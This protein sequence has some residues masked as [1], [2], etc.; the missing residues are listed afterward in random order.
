MNV[1]V[2]ILTENNREEM[3]KRAVESC[4]AQTRPVSQIIV[5]NDGLTELKLPKYPKVVTGKTPGQ[6]GLA[7]ARQQAFELLKSDC[8][9]VC[10]LDD[11]DELL[12]NHSEKLVPLLYKSAYGVSRAKFQYSDGMST[13]DPEPNNTGP[14]RYYDPEALLSQNIAP[15]SSYIHS[16]A[17]GFEV[18]WDPTIIRIEDWDFWGR[19]CIRY[20]PPAY[21]GAITNI[22]H[23][24]G[25]NLSG[26]NPLS[27]SMSCSWRDIVADRLR[28]LAAERRWHPT[29]E[30][31]ARFHIP[32][33]GVVMP[34][35]NAEK[36]LA[37]AVMSILRQTYGD[38]EIIAVNDGSTD[39][40]RAI[41]E[42]FAESDRRVRI[43]D[44]PGN[45]GVTKALNYGLLVS[46]S[47]YVARMDA[48][49]VSLPER[50]A[51]QMDFLDSNKDVSL[52]GTCFVSMDKDLSYEI[53]RNNIGGSPDEILTKLRTSNC[54]GHPTVMVRRRALEQMGG[55]NEAEAFRGAEDYELWARMAAKGKRLANLHDFLLLHRTYEGQVTSRIRPDIEPIRDM[56][57]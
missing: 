34:V 31:K 32:K 50:F 18:G 39:G 9:A 16:V 22:I 47:E 21:T 43:F 37:E 44:M 49:D 42:K 41:L 26:A 57:K 53:W 20:G 33:V 51:K 10:Y 27:Y 28:L 35:Y 7:G 29:K 30:D 36:Y 52:V 4:L 45:S 54:I 2:I 12:P 13:T 25:N 40:S 24:H 14:K 17:A 6:I 8:Q 23:K 3:L 48:D 11:D 5:M 1:S 15:V 38:F 56:L 55:Y 46:R 19:M